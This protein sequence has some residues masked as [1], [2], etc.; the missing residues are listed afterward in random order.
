MRTI[1]L[2]ASV[3]IAGGPSSAQYL[4]EIEGF[5]LREYYCQITVSLENQSDSPLTEISGFF[6]N[7]I[8]EEKVGRSKGAWFMSVA[9]GARAEATFET[10]N[11]PCDAVE[12]YEFVVGACRLGAGFEEKSVCAGLIRGSGPIVV[13][14][15]DGS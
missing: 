4:L 11:A 5:G 1:A 6:Y 9:P 8:G 15:P 10:P 3:M 7:Y 13:V 12:R 2:A 14:A